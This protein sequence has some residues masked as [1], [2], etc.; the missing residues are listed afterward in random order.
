MYTEQNIRYVGILESFR[1]FYIVTRRFHSHTT[2]TQIDFVENLRAM[3]LPLHIFTFFYFCLAS[4]ILYTA[5]SKTIP[6]KYLKF[7]IFNSEPNI[8]RV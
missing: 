8:D 4:K 6:L 7:W 3:S 1:F 2:R 5:K